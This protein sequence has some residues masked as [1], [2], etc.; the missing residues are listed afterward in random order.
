[1]TEQFSQGINE[2]RNVGSCWIFEPSCEHIQ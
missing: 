1:M 2:E